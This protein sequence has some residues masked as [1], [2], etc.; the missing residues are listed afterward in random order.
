[1]TE[2]PDYPTKSSKGT[3]FKGGIVA[4][5]LLAILGW[6][7]LY[8]T[9]SR[10]NYQVKQAFITGTMTCRTNPGTYG[11]MFGDIKTYKAASRYYFS[12][13]TEEGGEGLSAAPINVTFNGRSKA[14]VT[15]FLKYELPIDCDNLKALDKKYGSTEAIRD[16]II[17]QTVT[18]ALIQT[19]PLFTAE[20][21]DAP[22][23][24]QFREIALAQIKHGIYKKK[25]RMQKY[26]DPSNPNKTLRRQVTELYRDKDGNPVVVE[27]SPLKDFGI[28][29]VNF[30]IKDLD[31][32][33]V[34]DQ[35]LAKKKEIDM[36][37]TLQKAGAITAQQKAITEEAEG[38]ARV[39]KAEADALVIKKTAIIAE[40]QLKEV[41][42]LRAQKKYEI[43]KYA[44]KEA[45]ENAKKVKA[46]G[47]AKAAA[48]RALVSAGLTPLA[49]AELRK[50]TMIGMM[51]AWAKRPVPSTIFGGGSSK[52][53][54][55]MV[56]DM[57]GVDAA[58]N[59]INRMN[60]KK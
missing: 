6:S 2:S 39:A 1:M 12:K 38:R 50:E 59:A 9:N 42:A 14:D 32:D 33:D 19:A 31:W 11:Q 10:G 30:N 4:V 37:R 43:A 45:L 21:A 22:R 41:A 25:V 3:F 48:N 23:R 29:V 16:E 8:E 20:E 5:L 51:E 56:M 26:T 52:G 58:F 36:R 55:N 28:K 53:G 57:L 54:N 17:R 24:D 15:G 44:A 40:Q 35:L 46:N 60:R 49:A 13:H 27:D 18:E 47:M 7:S 34:T